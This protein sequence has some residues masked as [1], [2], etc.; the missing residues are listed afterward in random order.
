MA[1]KHDGRP[2]HPQYG[3]PTSGA[4]K[5]WEGITFRPYRVGV[6]RYARISDDFRVVVWDSPYSN[7]FRASV[8]GRFLEKKFRKPETAVRAACAAIKTKGGE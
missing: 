3:A 5:V 2:P 1:G 6:N 4:P 7:T 8:D